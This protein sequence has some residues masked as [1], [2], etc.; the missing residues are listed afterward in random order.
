MAEIAAEAPEICLQMSYSEEDEA[1]IV[2]PCKV[3]GL[4]HRADGKPR[5][6]YV[7]IFLVPKF[8]GLLPRP[9]AS[10]EIKRDNNE[11]VFSKKVEYQSVSS[12][13]LI[14][15][16]LHV[17][18]LEY[19]CFHMHTVLGNTD[20]HLVHVEFGNGEVSLTLPLE[21]PIVSL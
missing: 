4:P 5:T 14:N 1:F 8:P 2:H 3:T 10:S 13:E 17:E 6:T 11:P 15:S 16:V 19:S 18:V 20:L 9:V 21:M 7:R 12:H